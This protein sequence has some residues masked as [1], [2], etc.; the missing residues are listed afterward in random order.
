MPGAGIVKV[1]LTRTLAADGSAQSPS[2]TF[3]HIKDRKIIAVLTLAG[4]GPGTNVSFERYLNGNRADSKSA[5]LTRKEKFFYFN[6]IA[7]AGTTLA[8]GQYRLRFSVANRAVQEATY[9]VQ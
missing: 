6:F 3:D 8:V 1:E 7:R 4:L 9:V 2:T 5:T